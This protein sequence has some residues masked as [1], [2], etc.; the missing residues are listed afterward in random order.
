[1]NKEFIQHALSD[2]KKHMEALEAAL[3]YNAWDEVEFC[4]QVLIT[5]FTS[6]VQHVKANR[7]R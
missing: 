2:A 6:I 1:M 7:T 3:E 5:I 4:A